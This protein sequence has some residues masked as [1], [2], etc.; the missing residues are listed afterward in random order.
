MDAT[1]IVSSIMTCDPATVAPDDSIRVAIEQMQARNCRRLPV[2][3]AGKLVGI[4]T[5]TDL[6]NYLIAILKD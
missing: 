5:E 6:L 3:D 2:M 1:L 4:I